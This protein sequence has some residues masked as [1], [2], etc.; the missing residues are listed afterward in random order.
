MLY[1]HGFRVLPFGDPD[2]DW[3]SLDKRAFGSSG[4]KLNRQQVF[5]RIRIETPHR[6]LSE[7][8]NREGLGSVRSVGCA[9]AARDV[10]CSMSSFAT[11]STRLTNR[12]SCSSVRNSS[13]TIRFFGWR[14]TLARA[15]S[16]LR[17]MLDGQFEQETRRSRVDGEA[18]TGRGACCAQLDW[19]RLKS[20]RRKIGSSSSISPV[21]VL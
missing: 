10:D 11:S 3:I 20:N 8:T 16:D 14:R 17:G 1:R 18:T 12:R 7:Q 9:N 4:F 2:D 6:Y 15:V 5:G 19:T 21:S 13:K